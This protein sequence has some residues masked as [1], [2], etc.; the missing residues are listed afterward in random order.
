MNPNKVNLYGKFGILTPVVGFLVILSAVLSAPWFNWWTNAL[1][2]LG[3]EG[4]SATIFN[5]GLKVTAFLMVIFSIG[6]KEIAD[7]DKIG[8]AGFMLL[9]LGSIS[10]LGIGVFPEGTELHYPFSVTFFV[11]MPLSIW[12]IGY[13]F[14]RGG[15]GNIG[16]ISIVLGIAAAI[17]W[18]PKWDGV[19]IPETISALAFAIWAQMV[20]SLMMKIPVEEQPQ[21]MS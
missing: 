14:I 1:S 18:I 11:T 12:V 20:G 7:E 2:D 9:L 19:A 16:K 5:N 10:L 13:F 4:L 8:L 21:I 3:V 15:L 6:I 17:I